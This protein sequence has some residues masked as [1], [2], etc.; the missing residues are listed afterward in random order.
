MENIQNENVQQE[1]TADGLA[2][3]VGRVFSLPKTDAGM[4]SP[5]VLAYIGDGVYELAVRTILVRHGNIQVNKLNTKAT[6]LVKAEA[7]ASLIHAIAEDLTP[8]EASVYR[9]GRN[10]KSYT[11]A[12]HATMSDYRHATGLEALCGYLYLKQ[13]Y[14]RMAELLKLA[15]DRTGILEGVWDT[16]SR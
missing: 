10:A 8:E 7:Q 3:A 9:R 4:Y 14:D 1:Q 12:K 5:L 2:E 11:V 6:K 13:E 16:T 15:M